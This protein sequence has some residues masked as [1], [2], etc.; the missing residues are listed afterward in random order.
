MQDKSLVL[1]LVLP[2]RSHIHLDFGLVNYCPISLILKISYT[3]SFCHF[4]WEDDHDNSL[5]SLLETESCSYKNTNNGFV[6]CLVLL[7]HTGDSWFSS[8]WPHITWSDFWILC[9]KLD[10]HLKKAFKITTHFGICI[11]EVCR[12]ITKETAGLRWSPL[13]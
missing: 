8:W 2:Q 5:H 12:N 11:G 7:V 3:I 13:C 1:C 9:P 4:Q 6:R 10:F